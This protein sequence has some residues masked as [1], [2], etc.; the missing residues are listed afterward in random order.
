[1]MPMRRTA[2][3]GLFLVA[4]LAGPASGQSCGL[5][6][7]LAIEATAGAASYDLGGGRDGTVFGG[8]IAAVPGGVGLRGRVRALRMDEGADPLTGDLAV[9]VPALSVLGLDVCPTAR[10]GISTASMDDAELTSLAGGVGLRLAAA[11]GAGHVLPYLEVRGLAAWTDARAFDEDIGETGF[12][13][14][15][16]AGLRLTFGPLVLHAVGA[17]DGL[18]RGLGLPPYPNRVLEGGL[19]FRF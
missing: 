18:D 10:A 6:R 14:G 9:S 11:M 2:G 4:L 5:P 7:G 17:L 12:A 13:V 15:V 3:A 1:M 16:E 19:G 8:A